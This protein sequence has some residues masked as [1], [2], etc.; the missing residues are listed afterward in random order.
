MAS[1]TSFT[2]YDDGRK[3]TETDALNH[4]TTYLYDAAGRLTSIAGP[5]GNFTYAYDAAG[6]RI[7]SADGNGN[8][9]TFQYDARKRLVKTVYPDKTYTTNSYD[10]PGNLIG[11]TDQAGKTV[12][13]T[14]DA[15]NQLHSVIQTASPNTANTTSYGY[16]PLGNLA[17]LTDANSHSTQN[18]F[19]VFSDITGKTLPDGSLQESRTYDASGNLTQL[20]HFSGKTTTYAYDALNRLTTRTPDPTLVS[21]PVVSYTYTPTN[22]RATMTDGSGTTTYTYDPLDRL[23]TKATPEGTLFYGYDGVGNLASISSNH[24]NGISVSLT[25]DSLNRLSTVVDNRLQGNQTTTYT[26]D[27]ANNIVTRTAPN[28]L[29]TTFNYDPLNR[30][31]GMNSSISSYSYQLGSTGN[32]TGATEQNGRTLTWNYDGIYRL[33]NE[34]IGNDPSG[35]NGTASYG[36]DPVGNRLSLTSTLTGLEA[37]IFGY[38]SDDEMSSETYDANGNAL[39]MSGM[40]FAYDSE[41]HL[42]SMNGGQVQLIYDGDGNRVAK[43]VGGVITQYLVDD[44]NPTG[45]P[46]VVEEVVNGAVT[47]QYTYGL[48]RISENQIIANLWTPSFYEYDGGG[49]VRQLTNSAGQVTDK[50]EYDAFGHSFTLSGTTPNNY[51]Y[52]GEQF[53]SDLGLYYLRA[54]YYNPVT[55][56]FLSRDPEDGKTLDPRSLHK[57]LYAA[58][59][60]VNLFDPTGRDEVE[61]RLTMIP[62][63]S[64]PGPIAE[65]VGNAASRAAT[66]AI[67]QFLAAMSA[68]SNATAVV[69]AYLAAVDWVS[70]A[71]GLTKV[72]LCGALEVG[73]DALIDKLT[74]E[75]V[76]DFLPSELTNKFEEAC[77]AVQTW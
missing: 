24:A 13:Y 77:L 55:G 23:T 20:T 7:S 30:L 43:I 37:G 34:T 68:A 2:Y 71:K 72:L 69:A 31:T 76:S 6:N 61:Y 70:L 50:Y 4:T 21:E 14:Y 35:N 48:Q 18:V 41:N 54:R 19:D 58:G 63:G 62:G 65:M 9:T 45:L 42:T 53:D 11:V 3:K 66:F 12:N 75:G 32:R 25:Y 60:P 10:G 5:K 49:S 47:R 46:Q 51:L 29:Q 39:T 57:Y 8:T 15:A 22:K 59:D 67:N 28:G 17:S 33:T 44:L 38:N 26:Y 16:D 64:A 1:T 73:L 74:T 52:Q 36:L 56:R 40:S 27:P